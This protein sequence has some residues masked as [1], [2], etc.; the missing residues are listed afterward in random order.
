M[1]R[2]GKDLFQRVLRGPLGRKKMK[3]R[4][5]VV[6]LVEVRQLLNLL[7]SSF[8]KSNHRHMFFISG[9]TFSSDE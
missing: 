9:V 4:R 2:T 7:K 6:I 1:Q 8:Y 5:A 3:I